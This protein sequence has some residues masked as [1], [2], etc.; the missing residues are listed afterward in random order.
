MVKKTLSMT[1]AASRGNMDRDVQRFSAEI[2]MAALAVI[3][4]FVSFVN[5]DTAYGM[6][7]GGCHPFPDCCVSTI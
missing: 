5:P 4:A 2:E 3:D 6:K 7:S 1:M